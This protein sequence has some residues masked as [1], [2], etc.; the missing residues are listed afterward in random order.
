MAERSLRSISSSFLLSGE[1][2]GIKESKGRV[3]LREENSKKKT[4]AKAIIKYIHNKISMLKD[5][6]SIEPGDLS[7]VTKGELYF[8]FFC[9]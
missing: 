5:D 6:T 3:T 8:S 4:Q 1:H 7:I 2:I 9:A